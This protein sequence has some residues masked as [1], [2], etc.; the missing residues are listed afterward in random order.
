M[1]SYSDARV[2]SWLS[3]FLKGVLVLGALILVAR[4]IEL[5]V[6]KGEYFRDLAE[7]NRI[8]KV[9][10]E[11]P[12]GLILARGGEVM[13]DN[14]K[15]YKTVEFS[16]SEGVK[17]VETNRESSDTIVE[18]AR[19]YPFGEMLAHVTGYISEVNEEEVGKVHSGCT[20]KGTRP[21]GT[22]IGRVG[23]ERQYDCKLRGINGEEFVEVDTF[24]NK[25]RTLG[26]RPPQ[27][28][29]DIR[30]T[31]D[32]GFQKKAFEALGD[33]NGAI[34]VSDETGE[35]LALV[36]GPSFDPARV[37][38]Y[39]N[40]PSQPLL[41]RAIGG[42]YHPG[43]VYKLV[44]ASAALEEGA[45]DSKFE[46]N[47]KGYVTVNGFTYTNWY[48][49]Q[50]GG[51]EGL[52]GVKR[53]LARSTD[54]FFYE[55]G[56]KLG[57]DKLLAWSERFGLGRS[58][59]IDLPG[60]IAGLLSSPS[61]KKAVKGE[62]WFLGD[63]FNISIGQGDMAVTPIQV[64]AW[65]AAFANGGKL[66]KPHLL[67]DAG[68]CSEVGVSTDT[69]KIV[70]QGLVDACNPGG[71]GVA[72]FEYEPE[73]AC[74][75]GTAETF[76]EGVTHAWFTVFAPADNPEIVVTVLLE[77]GGSGSED[78]APLAREILDLWS[79]RKNP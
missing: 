47:D 5:Q 25:I 28:G 16:P 34:I 12:R 56:G 6:I 75:T 66:C 58:T 51:I 1:E 48:F 68:A 29:E 42:A 9:P 78:A 37:A 20:D 52:I 33:K 57:V 18:P 74:K 79:L 3:W 60:E 77:K 39:L 54:T 13:V 21:L 55:V 2:Q 36:S 30:T 63:T 61:W 64:H 27:A 23:L 72:F 43:S 69:I 17:K 14:S 4:L 24:G 73:V 26:A 40:S 62:R 67:R 11:A 76:E 46:Y 31:I 59:G 44:G 71:T 65:T 32:I 38:D 53:A 49:T 15:V 8:R 19:I 45:I 41:N 10:I 35:I 7:G 22:P 70:N 50:Y